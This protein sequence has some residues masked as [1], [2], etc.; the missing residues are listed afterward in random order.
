MDAGL[1]NRTV[2]KFW[3]DF[4]LRNSSDS[5]P[6]SMNQCLLLNMEDPPI[7]LGGLDHFKTHQ[8]DHHWLYIYIYVYI[9]SSWS[10]VDRIWLFKNIFTTIATEQNGPCYEKLRIRIRMGIMLGIDHVIV[11]GMN[12]SCNTII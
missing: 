10:R 6:V 5:S 7:S 2:T 1:N 9:E 3:Q 8:S 11:I 4:G 12:R